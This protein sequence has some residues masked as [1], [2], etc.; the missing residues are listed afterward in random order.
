[1]KQI[2]CFDVNHSTRGS[3]AKDIYFFWSFSRW[4]SFFLLSLMVSQHRPETE[5]LSPF[6]HKSKTHHTQ[7]NMCLLK[8]GDFFWLNTLTC[9]TIKPTIR[10]ALVH[11]L[12]ELENGKNKDKTICPRIFLFNFF[13]FFKKRN[14]RP[15][16][17]LIVQ[18]E[19][20]ICTRTKTN[21]PRKK[22]FVQGKNYLSKIGTV[23]LRI[24]VV[25]K[26]LSVQEKKYLPKENN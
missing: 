12:Q 2:P 17:K 23:C 14:I 21:C 13:N 4:R 7:R 20:T 1:M 9:A 22:L 24:F 3:F 8:E 15:R 18:E 10:F 11:Q 6:I 19:Q 5:S 16:K 26:D 25:L